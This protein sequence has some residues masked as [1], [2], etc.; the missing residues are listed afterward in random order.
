MNTRM[1]RTTGAA[2]CSMEIGLL[3]QYQFR[4]LKPAVFMPFK[5]TD[6]GLFIKGLWENLTL[7]STPGVN[8]V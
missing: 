1:I 8:A 4:S 3:Q 6:K 2:Q 5:D 7:P